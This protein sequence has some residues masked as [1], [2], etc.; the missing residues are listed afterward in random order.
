VSSDLV[1]TTEPGAPGADEAAMSDV[2]TEIEASASAARADGAHPA[3]LD[4]ELD[5]A[6]ER[7]VR[8]RPGEDRLTH[9]LWSVSA[10]AHI[11]ADAGLGETASPAK[12]IAKRVLAKLIRWYILRITTQVTTFA[13]ATSNSLRLISDRVDAL[14]EEV[15]SIGPPPVP[16]KLELERT[17]RDEASESPLER[18]EVLAESAFARLSPLGKGKGCGRVLHADCRNGSF[19]ARLS[20]AGVDAYGVEP[21]GRLLSEPAAAGLDLV[22]GHVIDHLRNVPHGALSGIL[23]SGCVDRLTVRDARRLA[24]LI[25]SRLSAGGVVCI[26]GTQPATWEANASPV[27]RDLATGRPLHPETWAHLLAEQGIAGIE[28]A[29]APAGNGARSRV[30]GFLVSGTRTA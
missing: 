27:E 12:R 4:R 13:E 29:T 30:T 25:G 7:V 28:T 19:V 2:V 11:T 21:S 14:A 3:N 17:G 8:N 6:F 15:A 20:A 22:H 23:L 16:G 24:F 1:A 9:S 26:G 5:W 10:S 18:E